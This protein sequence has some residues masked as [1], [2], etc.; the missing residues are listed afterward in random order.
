MLN[1]FIQQALSQCVLHPSDLCRCDE[2]IKWC[3]TSVETDQSLMCWNSTLIAAY[4]PCH[5]PPSMSLSTGALAETMLFM[6]AA[7][8]FNASS[9]NLPLRHWAPSVMMLGV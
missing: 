2:E 3:D 1:D 6:K 9:N 7:K 5:L 4:L 8:L